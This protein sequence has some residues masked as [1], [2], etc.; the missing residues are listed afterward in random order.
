MKEDKEVEIVLHPEISK[1]RDD[2]DDPDLRKNLKEKG[3]L[4]NL[5]FR[6]LPDG[7]LQLLSGNR[8][9]RELMAMGIPFEK[10]EKKVLENVGDEEALLLAY[11]ENRW[12][13]DL[14]PLEEARAFQSMK[15]TLKQLPADI[16]A[17]VGRSESYVRDR[18]SLLDMPLEIQKLMMAD[19]LPYSFANT[20]KKLEAEPKM[21]LALAKQIVKGLSDS[22]RG[23]SSYGEIKT[24]ADAE[25][26]VEEMLLSKNHREEL[27]TKYGP[28]PQCGSRNLVDDSWQKNHLKC[29]N[30]KYEWNSVTKDPWKLYELKVAAK[31]MGLNLDVEGNKAKLTAAIE[32]KE[33]EKLKPNFRC[34][35]TVDELVMPLIRDRGVMSFRVDGDGIDISLIQDTGMHFSARKHDYD[36]GD[37]TM[38]RAGKYYGDGEDE[39]SV[40]KVKN[41]IDSLLD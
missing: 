13:R 22:S 15:R 37:K 35:R 1:W 36:S 9:Y 38:V 27:V 7:S 8:R 16:A 14:S 30:C 3:Q 29:V 32:E 10:M 12:R 41:Y 2:R 34:K 33:K 11:S 28:C 25:K 19:K 39:D 40:K 24:V 23:F 17:K 4:Q 31:S 5:V 6:K 20:L 18:L 21:Q 26:A